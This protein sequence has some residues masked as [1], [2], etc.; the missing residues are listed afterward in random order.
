MLRGCGCLQLSRL[1]FPNRLLYLVADSS[2]KP[3]RTDEV[4]TGALKVVAFA[5]TSWLLITPLWQRRAK[6]RGFRSPTRM[7]SRIRRPLT[8]VMSFK[9][10]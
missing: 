7:V 4:Q 9:T 2:E 8:P 10:Q 5:V 6:V 3:P 1:E